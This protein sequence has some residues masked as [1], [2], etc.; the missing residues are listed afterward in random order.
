MS[1][2]PS[3]AGSP[4]ARGP[5]EPSFTAGSLFA[6]RSCISPATRRW[7][8]GGIAWVAEDG[9]IG[10]FETGKEADFIVLDPQATT[11]QARRNATA[12]NVD[13]RLFAL[14]MLGDDRSVAETYV[15]GAL[16]WA[17]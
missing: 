13:E 12:A 8:D 3:R 2:R 6:A 5:T 4:G 1:G 9:K 11:L 16:A 10:N 14:M 15:M 17:R 7:N